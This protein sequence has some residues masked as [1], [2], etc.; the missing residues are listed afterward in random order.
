MEHKSEVARIRE[1][2]ARE[3]QAAQQVFG[4]FTPTAKHEYLTKRQENLGIYFEELK[5]HISPE[6]AMQ[7]FMQVETAKPTDEALP[8][9][10]RDIGA[11]KEISSFEGTNQADEISMWR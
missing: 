5:K 9:P 3:Y 6:E 10:H 8:H 11:S 7:I 2:I 4:G 1:Q